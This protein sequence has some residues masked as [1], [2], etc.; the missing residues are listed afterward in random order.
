[1]ATA[2]NCLLTGVY[3]YDNLSSVLVF[4]DDRPL[5][6]EFRNWGRNIAFGRR[7]LGLSRKAFAARVGVSPQMVSRWERGQSVPADHRR[8]VIASVLRQD[9]VQVFPLTR[10]AR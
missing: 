2:D 10:S 4:L 8:P 1:M 7:A 6:E 3:R 9:V 5:A